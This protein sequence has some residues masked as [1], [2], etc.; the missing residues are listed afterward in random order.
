MRTV[1]RLTSIFA[2]VTSC[3]PRALEFDPANDPTKV[4]V[5]ASALP[6]VADPALEARRRFQNPGGMWTP[7][8]MAQHVV[9]LRELGMQ[10]DPQVLGDPLAFPLGA[11]VWLGGC[12]G[13]FVSADGLIVTNHH[14]A[15]GA[16]QYNSDS[17]QK[18]DLLHDGF[19]AKTR[20][21][22]R[23]NG[24]AA[25]VFVTRSARDV[26]QAVRGDLDA[27]PDPKQRFDRIEQRQKEIVAACEKGNP[28][29]RCN[30][31]SFF[32]GE[33]YMLIEQLELRDIRLVYAPA[34][35]V[36]NFGGEIDN[37]RWPRHSGDFTFFRAYVAPDQK[38]ADFDAK[39]VPYKPRHHLTVAKEALRPSDLVLVAGYPGRTSRLRTAIEVAEAVEW[40]YPRRIRFC[41]DYIALLER[42]AKD[43]KDLEIKGKNLW[44]GLAN[45]L[46]NTKG[47]LEGLVK[48]G[49]AAKRKTQ[50]SDLRSWAGSSP[51]HA[52]VA[53]ALD[54][55]SAAFAKYR[56]RRDEEAALQEVVMM[57][58]L[59]GAAD[60][61]VHMAL[62]RPKPDA[63]RDPAF[64]ERNHKR[65]VQTQRQQ[66][67]SYARKLE[68]ER[69]KLA[70]VRAAALP[71]DRR[72]KKLLA[73]VVP[74]GEPTPTAI[75]KALT[76]MFAKTTLEDVDARVKLL[77]S[78]TLEE[79]K[80]SEDPFLQLALALRPT[81]QQ[82][83]DA[84]E[85]FIGET[86]K[87]RVAYVTALRDKASGVLAPDANA[88]LRITYG[89]V[90]GYA[91][92]EGAPVYAP[93]T[94]LSE[95]VAKQTGTEPF[96][97]PQNLIE[98]AKAG[99]FG[100][101]VAP[102][103]GEVPVD[104]LSDLDITGGNSGSPTLNDRG[105]L[106]GL[107]FDG[108]YEAMASDW[109]FMPSITRSIHVDIRYPLWI[110]DRVDGAD[111][112]LRELGIEPKL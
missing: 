96:D 66:Q 85:A 41:E 67:Q 87:A 84:S 54:A 1:A 94:R 33:T 36:G 78:G 5:T 46:T 10:L 32:D 48:D 53:A 42:L 69:L 59:L 45:A 13:S 31:V 111:H 34:E 20:A 73:L 63:E 93:F 18:R 79:L 101:Y 21:E 76:T 55:F 92:R 103:L 22:E 70:L 12:T 107:V 61:I 44:R 24:P 90:R 37:W 86:L 88:S 11:V 83:E 51:E 29:L 71:E 23:S 57:S 89:T 68:H 58:T 17:S 49:L 38:P 112:L 4:G 9:T 47:Q 97:A 104:F 72:P 81:L 80:K 19:L 106:V 109:L 39:N 110:M 60:T 26:T 40:S 95:M 8:Q 50:E 105:E 14:C 6:P 15:T 108:N 43:D 99:P 56:A 30:V 74:K 102:E 35:G 65:I 2:L 82:I 77:E 75:D 52:G 62:E 100:P 91:P 3:A 27:I 25:R 28:E 64:Q 98:A 16:L 7:G